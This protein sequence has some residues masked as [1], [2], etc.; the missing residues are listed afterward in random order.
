MN[1]TGSTGERTRSG[2]VIIDNQRRKVGDFLRKELDPEALVS[3]VS[4]YFT[5]YAYHD[6]RAELDSIRK[7]RFLYG[8][9]R[10]V[11]AMD[12]GGADDKAFRL[13]K[14]GGSELKRALAQKPLALAC[15]SWIR[16]KVE[17]RTIEKSNFLHG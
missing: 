14:D 9:P 16:R 15:E 10:G 4:A 3:V 8:E 11:G 1:R 2:N 12:P 6:L 13:T 5:I 7:M 17:I